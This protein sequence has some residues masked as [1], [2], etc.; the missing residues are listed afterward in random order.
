MPL[1]KDSCLIPSSFK[2]LREDRFIGPE[3]VALA[4]GRGDPCSL[5]HSSRKQ[6]RP[7]R[8]AKS[9]HMKVAQAD[10]F[11]VHPVEVGCAYYGVPVATKVRPSLVIGHHHHNVWFA[12]SFFSKSS[13]MPF[14]REDK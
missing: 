12:R 10:T 2:I 4:I 14:S 6:S 9:I 3:E 7:G 13:N 8:G 11:L 1:S 5:R